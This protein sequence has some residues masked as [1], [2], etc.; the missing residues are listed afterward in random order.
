MRAPPAT[1]V[2]HVLLPD[3]TR[4]QPPTCWWTDGLHS[5]FVEAEA[6]SPWL[7][8]VPNLSCY[9]GPPSQVLG[10]DSMGRR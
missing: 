7:T 5:Q 9:Y 3:P 8:G 2:A 6:P 10:W 1:V 4:D